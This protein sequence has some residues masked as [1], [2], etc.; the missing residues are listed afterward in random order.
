MIA[1]LCPTWPVVALLHDQMVRRLSSDLAANVN[2]LGGGGGG[3]ATSLSSM[4]DNAGPDSSSS[5]RG[6]GK[7]DKKDS[8]YVTFLLDLLGA[9]GN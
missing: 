2:T 4:Q 3:S 9:I 8:T 6:G 5:G 1:L 7:G